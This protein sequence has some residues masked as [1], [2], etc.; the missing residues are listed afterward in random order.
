MLLEIPLDPVKVQIILES[1][2]SVSHSRNTVPVGPQTS[3]L[4]QIVSG[5]SSTFN[6]VTSAAPQAGVSQ[7]P[8]D[9]TYVQLGVDY[10]NDTAA[11]ET[12]S[13]S[14]VFSL[15]EGLKTVETSLSQ[16]LKDL[17][18]VLYDISRSSSTGIFASISHKKLQKTSTTSL[19]LLEK[20]RVHI[21][22]LVQAKNLDPSLPPLVH[23]L[24]KVNL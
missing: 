19:E 21:Q 4:K 5:V 3:K 2:R 13:V 9:S 16:S 10:E 12:S 20:L 24:E 14:P 7:T 15:E 22:T 8:K 17:H 18:D 23:R 1:A 6:G 11:P